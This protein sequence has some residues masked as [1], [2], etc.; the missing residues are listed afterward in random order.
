MYTA[1]RTHTLAP[2]DTVLMAMDMLPRWGNLLLLLAYLSLPP[3]TVI[4]TE[5]IDCSGTWIGKEKGK[6][7]GI[8]KEKRIVSASE[9][10]SGSGSGSRE[11]GTGRDLSLGLVRIRV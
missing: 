11:K 8:E 3:E 4:W 6:G 2:G 9:S 10:G 5:N 1:I 7:K